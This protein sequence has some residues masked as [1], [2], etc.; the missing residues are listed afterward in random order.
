[1][2]PKMQKRNMLLAT[3]ALTLLCLLKTAALAQTTH[4]SWP[5]HNGQSEHKRAVVVRIKNGPVIRGRLLEADK[6]SIRLE[7]EDISCP[8][9]LDV[10]DVASIVFPPAEVAKK[11]P[12]KAAQASSPQ[13]HAEAPRALRNKFYRSQVS[14]RINQGE[15]AAR[16]GRV[17]RRAA[18]AG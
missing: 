3:L 18:T 6:D 1:M 15:R 10:R 5:A 7:V 2:D 17:R 11:A 9:T 4:L 13:A 14:P 16:R 12:Q 8:V